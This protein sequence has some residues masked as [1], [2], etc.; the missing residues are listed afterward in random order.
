MIEKDRTTSELKPEVFQD[1]K[2]VHEHQKLKSDLD[3]LGLLQ[4]AWRFR[5]AVLICFLLC[6]AAAADGYQVGDLQLQLSHR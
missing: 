2:V 4:T 6:V 5:K 3:E 1:E